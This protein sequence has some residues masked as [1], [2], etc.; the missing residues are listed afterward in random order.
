M[1]KVCEICGKGRQ[2]GHSVSHANNKRKK[3]W[4]ANLQRIRVVTESGQIKRLRVCTSCISSGK[5]KK[6]TA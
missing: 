3:V 4:N 1:S 2:V 6:A 5:V